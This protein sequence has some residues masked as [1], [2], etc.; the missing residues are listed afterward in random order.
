MES[1][2]LLAAGLRRSWWWFVLIGV[3]AL[4][5][6]EVAGRVDVTA[7]PSPLLLRGDA[8]H[9]YRDPAVVYEQGQFHLFYTFNPPPDP[10][11]KVYWYVAVS[12][13][14]D[15]R[16]WTE[17]CLLTPKD[18]SRN[19][20]SPGNVIRW[21]GQWMLCLQTY[22]LPQLFATDPVRFADDTARVF[23][24]RSDDLVAWSE[25]ELLRVKGPQVPV[26]KMGRMIDPF[27]LEDA[28]EPGKWWCFFKQNGASR[29]W[30]H[31][32]VTWTYDGH[33][34]AG[35]NV[36]ILRDGD[37]YVLFH[38]P[39]NGIGVKRSSDLVHWR[40]AGLLVLGQPQWSWARQG[41]LTAGFVL[42]LR[43][44]P[45]VGKALM[46]FHASAYPEKEPRGF[47]AHCSIGM[48]WSEDLTTWHWPGQETGT[49]SPP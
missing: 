36:C 18:Q 13:S 34:A 8:T 11:G 25:P 24:M 48:A 14:R 39:S 27:L 28:R 29:A 45:R 12:R 7:L 17:P 49:L 16:H 30:S 20:S 35:E 43:R 47:W 41:R 9:A 40:D 15:L 23:V 26:Q 42:D 46:F 4:L 33:F 44:D 2:A 5:G 3:P 1:I 6:A 19:F 10:D 38:S 37:E 32:L 21:G 31:D 22:P